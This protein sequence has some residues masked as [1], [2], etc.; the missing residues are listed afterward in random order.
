MLGFILSLLAIGIAAGIV[1]RSLL[2]DL[3]AVNPGN[4]MVLGIIGSFIGGLLGILI[5]GVGLRLDPVGIVGSILGAGVALWIYNAVGR[6]PM[7]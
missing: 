4:M 6:R 5:R 2:P 3:A 7:R 1:A